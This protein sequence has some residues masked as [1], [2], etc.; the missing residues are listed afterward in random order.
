MFSLILIASL[1]AAARVLSA[2]FLASNWICSFCWYAW[3]VALSIIFLASSNA[4][5]LVCSAS[6]NCF[7]VLNFAFSASLIS[8]AM[9]SRRFANDSFVGFQTNQ[10]QIDIKVIVATTWAK[11]THKFGNNDSNT[12]SFSTGE[13]LQLVNVSNGNTTSNKHVKKAT[14]LIWFLFMKQSFLKNIKQRILK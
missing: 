12:P 14:N 11:N 4:L 2:I 3:I 5:I 1:S 9:Y 10:M 13:L 6:C 7:R 8:L